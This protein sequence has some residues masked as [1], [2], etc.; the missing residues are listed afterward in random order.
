MFLGDLEGDIA[1]GVIAHMSALIHF[2]VFSRGPY[3]V[4][5][6]ADLTEKLS[7]IMDDLS[8]CFNPLGL[9]FTVACIR[10]FGAQMPRRLSYLGH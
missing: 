1:N 3:A 8:T 10:D 4:I 9:D 5:S 6:L 7:P 2:S